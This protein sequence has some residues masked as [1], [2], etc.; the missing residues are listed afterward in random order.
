[1]LAQTPKLRFNTFAFWCLDMSVHVSCMIS[2]DSQQ[3][4]H[5]MRQ[6]KAKAFVVHTHICMIRLGWVQCCAEEQCKFTCYC[7][8]DAYVKHIG[9]IQMCVA[10]MKTCTVLVQ[11]TLCN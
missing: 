8:A 7:K 11:R 5:S 6:D 1:M 10:R 9:Y 3:S 2:L 4:E